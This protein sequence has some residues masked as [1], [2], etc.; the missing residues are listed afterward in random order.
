[1][2]NLQGLAGSDTEA[3]GIV[4]RVSL[5][6][7]YSTPPHALLGKK[8]AHRNNGPQGISSTREIRNRALPGR[9]P[10]HLR[11]LSGSVACRRWGALGFTRGSC[12]PAA[13][14]SEPLQETE[15]RSLDDLEGL[16]SPSWAATGYRSRFEFLSGAHMRAAGAAMGCAKRLPVQHIS[17]LRCSNS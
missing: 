1:M 3:C 6:W 2:A 5:L 4:R 16:R 13:H 11:T 8:R 12:G 9:P 17:W 14:K 7:E 10:P 15:L